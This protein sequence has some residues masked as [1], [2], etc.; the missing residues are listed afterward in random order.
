MYFYWGETMISDTRKE[1]FTTLGKN[2]ERYSLPPLC[3]WIE[4]LLL[5]EP[6]DWTQRDLSQR[7]SELFS[8]DDYSTSLSS[9]NRALKILE[10]YGAIEKSGSRKLGYTYNLASSSKML[11]N[12]FLRF[13][14][15][16]DSFIYDL[17]VL[18]KNKQL[19]DDSVLQNTIEAQIE[20]YTAFTQFLKQ[21]IETFDLEEEK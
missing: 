18:K 2:Y 12:I 13:I 20:G 14:S 7:L 16:N 19:E 8:D 9:V 10:D 1:F 21:F 3:G 11:T 5:L 17:S 6:K 15:Y 4:A